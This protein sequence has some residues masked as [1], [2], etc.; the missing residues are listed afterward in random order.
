MTNLHSGLCAVV[1]ATCITLPVMAPLCVVKKV[2][3]RITNRY[4]G[5]QA[6]GFKR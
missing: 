5:P 6:R 4:G 3:M 2:L 1:P